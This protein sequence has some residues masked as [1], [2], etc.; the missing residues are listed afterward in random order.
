MP[1]VNLF[2]G[3]AVNYH[4]A[5]RNLPDR[6]LFIRRYTQSQVLQNQ[7][8]TLRLSLLTVLQKPGKRGRIVHGPCCHIVSAA[9]SGWLD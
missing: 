1:N 4:E 2:R 3:F 8:G 5:H 6:L 9:L 7:E